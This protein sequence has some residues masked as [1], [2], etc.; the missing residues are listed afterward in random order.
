MPKRRWIVALV[1][2]GVVGLAAGAVA[3]AAPSVAAVACPQCYGLTGLGDGVFAED[4]AGRRQMIE[5]ASRRVAA[6]YGEQTT[7]PRVL[8]CSTAACY[9]R[10]GGGGEKGRALRTGALLLA[11]AGANETIAAHELSHLE[12]HERLG[13][14]RD[15]VPHWFDEGLAV[16]V[17]DDAR[18]LRPAGATD[19][20]RLP[21][22]QAVTVVDK[23][24]GSAGTGA[25]DHGYLQAA[26]VVSR[27][28]GEH[29]GPAGVLRVIADLRA[30][31]DFA[32][33]VAPAR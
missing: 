22:E 29:G 19:R 25:V 14:A 28:A 13:S 7:H 3:V 9:R 8:I 20:C 23:P 4:P 2:A 15:R 33:L 18:Y 17:A 26:C 6:F 21:Y 27:W 31:K 30:G 5:A 32:A 12:F 1:T 10:I 24:W 11:P 16:L